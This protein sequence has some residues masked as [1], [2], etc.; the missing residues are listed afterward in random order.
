MRRKFIF[1]MMSLLIAKSVFAKTTVCT[2]LCVTESKDTV[3]PIIVKGE[4]TEMAVK[5]LFKECKKI[6]NGHVQKA[7]DISIKND[8]TAYIGYNSYVETDYGYSCI[9]L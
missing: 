1:A 7:L 5:N 4:T 2:A 8:L 6:K 3:L 9:G